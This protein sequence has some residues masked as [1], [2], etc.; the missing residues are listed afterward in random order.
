MTGEST[1]GRRLADFSGSPEMVNLMLEMQQN[2]LML[3]N[4]AEK[5]QSL[6]ELTR[7]VDS[8]VT[9]METIS[10]EVDSIENLKQL[11]DWHEKLWKLIASICTLLFPALLASIFWL[12][13]E[14]AQ[15]KNKQTIQE[16]KLQYMEKLNEKSSTSTDA[17]SRVDQL[18]WHL[19]DF[20]GPRIPELSFYRTNLEEQSTKCKLYSNRGVYVYL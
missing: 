7:K 5:V 1:M 14:M 6:P 19:W 20:D 16:F 3:K 17:N 15:L 10:D 11:V 2:S 4:V 12:S 8:L 13:T 9:Q 18:S